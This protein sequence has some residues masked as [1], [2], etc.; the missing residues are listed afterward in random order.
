[1]NRFLK[2]SIYFAIVFSVSGC[3]TS[4]NA[5]SDSLDS[6]A[7]DEFGAVIRYPE[8]WR[9]GSDNYF[10]FKA[11]GFAPNDRP[12]SIEY[13]GLNNEIQDEKKELYARGWY[14]AINQNYPQWT[15]IRKDSS[16][17]ENRTIYEFEGTYRIAT[18]TY[19]K[20]GRLHFV[21]KRV[22]AVYYTTLDHEFDRVR[23]YF[24]Q[25]DEAHEFSE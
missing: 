4:P 3:F 1:M 16:E 22:H 23:E 19:R 10:Q 8:N 11:Y 21:G 7:L 2:V 13:R 18:D 25:I 14:E 24:I 9:V 20:I 17:L 12:A 5:G 6:I 15:Y